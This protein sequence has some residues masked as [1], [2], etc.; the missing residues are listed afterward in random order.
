M[1]EK[2]VLGDDIRDF[3]AL[4]AVEVFSCRGCAFRAKFPNGFC[5]EFGCPDVIAVL[6]TP[7][8]RLAYDIERTKAR[9]GV[10]G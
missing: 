2:P 6:K 3:E 7:E 10:K 8:A 1:T 5:I 9:L 4:P